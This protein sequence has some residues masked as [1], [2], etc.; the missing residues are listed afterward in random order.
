[1]LLHH[2]GCRA[3]PVPTAVCL[4]C[5]VSALHPALALGLG[6]AKILAAENGTTC[7]ESAPFLAH[8]TRVAAAVNAAVAKDANVDLFD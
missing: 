3:Q 7:E 2:A 4:D 1:M 5:C 8:P 6:P